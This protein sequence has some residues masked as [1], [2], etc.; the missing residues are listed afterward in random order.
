MTIEFVNL[1]GTRTPGTSFDGPPL[2]APIDIAWAQR[3]ARTLDEVGFDYT[4]VP[5]M[6]AG[7]DPFVMSGAILAAT[8]RLKTVVA[9]RPNI[10]FPTVAAQ[11]LATLDQVSGGRTIVHVISGG[12]DA[13][14]QRQGDYLTKE[15]RYRRTSEFI[16]VLRDVWTAEAP[17]SHHGEF[18]D[19]DDFGPGLRTS[20]GASLPVSVGGSSGFAHDVGGALGDIVAFYG[21]PLAQIAEQIANVCDGAR[22]AGRTDRIR[23]WA[24]FRP[25]V[26][27]TDELA[28]ARARRLVEQSSEFYTSARPQASTNVGSTRLRDIAE[29]AETHDGGALWTPRSIA[30]NGGASSLI[31]G[32]PET[33]AEALVKYVELGVDIFSLPTLGDLDDMIDAGRQIIPLVRQ[34]VAERGLDPE[35]TFARQAQPVG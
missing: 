18:F 28:R 3:Y 35:L 21:E 19:F 24:T 15:Q 27:E 32:S 6:S 34:K 20:S 7:Y 22:K 2:A 25:I 9:V 4:L 5:Y 31:V 29:L 13:E 14:Q 8:T 16:Q 12:N 11:A 17:I 1:I 10:S 26:A 33:I 30:G 23:F